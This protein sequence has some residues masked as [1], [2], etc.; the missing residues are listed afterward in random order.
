MANEERKFWKIVTV[1]GQ[2]IQRK[3]DKGID[4]YIEW[5]NGRREYMDSQTVSKQK[6]NCLGKKDSLGR[7]VQLP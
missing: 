5:E 1:N 2:P 3:K 6:K 4:V 7:V